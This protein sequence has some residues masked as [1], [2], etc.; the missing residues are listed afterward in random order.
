MILTTFGAAPAD[1][2]PSVP[3]EVKGA[4][5]TWFETAF[6]TWTAEVDSTFEVYV[7][8]KNVIDWR[9]GS[10][11]TDWLTDWTLVNDSANAPLVRVV[12]PARSTWRVDIPGLPQGDYEIQVRAENGRVR[13]IFSD[14]RTTSFSR[15]GAAF[16]PS[17]E[18]NG[19]EGSN[20]F[21][22]DGSTGGY[23][24]DGRVDPAAAIVYVT[25]D[26]MKETLAGSA[27]SEPAVIEAR[28]GV[29]GHK[30]PMIIRF[31][32][33][34][35]SVERVDRNV[36]RSGTVAPP[37]VDN[38]NRMLKLQQG[39]GNLTFEGV[40]PDAVINAWGINTGGA[41][42]IVVRN[43]TFDQNYGK[44][45]E[46]NGG[47][48]RVRASNIWVHNNTFGVGQNRYLFLG[49]D[50]DN[51]KGDGS[52]DV[53]N[54]ARNYTIA[55]NHYAGS[56]KAMLIGGNAAEMDPHYGTINHNWF[57]VSEERT[58]RVRGG[59][60][61]VFN[62]LYEDVQ[63]HPHHNSLAA[64]NTGYG[65]GAGHNANIWAEGNIFDNVNFPFI[66]SRQ[67][68]ARGF[69]AIDYVPGPG[70]TDNFNAGLNHLF[71]DQ[72]G[73]IV[74]REVVTE[75]DFPD[76][77]EDFRRPT[78]VM[79]YGDSAISGETLAELKEAALA[80]EPN[81]VLDQGQTY[82]DPK[83]DIGV[84]VAEGSTE[85]NPAMTPT[86][87]DVKPAQLDWKFRPTENNEV[88]ATGTDTE[89]AELRQHIESFSGAMRD[90]RPTKRP[91]APRI[92][93][94]AINGQQM[95]ALDLVA[96]HDDTFTIDWVDNDALTSSFELQWDN[97]TGKWT[98]L[99]EAD[100]TARPNR[101]VTQNIDQFAHVKEGPGWAFAQRGETYRF[102]IRALN[103]AG[104]S[105]WSDAYAVDTVVAA[106]P[107]AFLRGLQGSQNELSITVAET[108]WD[109]TTAE[110]SEM[111]LI[112][113]NSAGTYAVG[114]YQVFVDTRGN[115]GVR[116]IRLVE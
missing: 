78:D 107:S 100:R 54:S 87:G 53:G 66:R 27:G 103:A 94:G 29:E 28:A 63:G 112:D 45:L 41:S 77:V 79:V 24:P 50:P 42:N 114:P 1:A 88:W 102:R 38:N 37:S 4:A 60:V 75:G 20:D 98:T 36:S 83:L 13:H 81:I 59:R 95:G 12:D 101:F 25:H 110:V 64:R 109:E 43:L 61:H 26:N 90:L 93:K 80:L 92:L 51:A 96:V 86:G 106:I 76:T 5:G 108:Y 35:G 14:L 85:T 49:H 47:G 89:V 57:E 34:V 115:D 104:A 70:E 113:N 46:I 99:M 91:D 65:I 3:T 32:G 68:H 58:P 21:A 72:P 52:T 116:D 84:V 40:G 82:F 17:S 2:A 73:F 15:N 67:G 48:F 22:L 18:S 33:T 55:Y 111:H 23:L 105:E 44:A 56:S 31:L 71:G 7:R 6:A 10:P 39:S 97:G 62:N 69:Q 9:D 74:T 8:G 30:Q 19:F 11:I 16:V